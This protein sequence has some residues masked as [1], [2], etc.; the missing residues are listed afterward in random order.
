MKPHFKWVKVQIK[1]LQQQYGEINNLIKLLKRLFA[2]F[3]P[4][5]IA[6]CYLHYL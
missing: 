5:I 3:T 2:Q 6:T 1:K 4:L